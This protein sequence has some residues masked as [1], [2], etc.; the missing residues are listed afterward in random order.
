MPF[1]H[2]APSWG[3]TAPVGD[4]VLQGFTSRLAETRTRARGVSS[5][6]SGLTGDFGSH[7]AR[8]AVGCAV[9]QQVH[10]EKGPPR[11]KQETAGHMPSPEAGWPEQGASRRHHRGDGMDTAVRWGR[12]GGPAL[13]PTSLPPLVPVA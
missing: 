12:A 11:P 4:Q 10:P 6:G 2:G 7:C 1:V 3:V 5:G 13:F 9:R 8:D